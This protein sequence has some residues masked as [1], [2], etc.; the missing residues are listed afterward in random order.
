MPFC[1]KCGNQLKQDSKFC[2]KCGAPS[3]YT[4]PAPVPLQNQNT[5]PPVYRNST[6][7][8]KV[9]L[10]CGSDPAYLIKMIT[11]FSIAFALTL[12]IYFMIIDPMYEDIMDKW[13]NFRRKYSDYSDTLDYKKVRSNVSLV[14]IGRVTIIISA[15]LEILSAI[16]F[17]FKCKDNYLYITEKGIYGTACPAFGY[18]VVRFNLEYFQVRCVT[19]KTGRLIIERRSGGKLH[20]CVNNTFEAKR[21]INEKLFSS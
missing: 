18:S 9:I 15:C 19:I 5:P 4:P 14:K 20:C 3:N 17:I 1:E 21:I 2:S 11:I 7:S 10:R 6:E 8:N 12:V 16:L 13:D